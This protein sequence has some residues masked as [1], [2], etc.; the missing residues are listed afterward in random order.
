MTEETGTAVVSVADRIKAKIQ[1]VAER[2]AP[3]GGNFIKLTKAK[4]FKLPDGE[5]REGPLSVVVLD[6]ISVNSYFDRPYR[7]GEITPPACFA[8]GD[9]PKALVPHKTAPAPQAKACDGCPNNEFGSKGAGKACQN[10]RLLAV[11]APGDDPAAPI[12]LIKVSPTGLKNWDAYIQLI[13]NRFNTAEFG[14]ITEIYFD[15]TKEYQSLKFGNPVVNPFVEQD[16]TR[17]TEARE[18]LMVAPDVSSYEAPTK[19]KGRK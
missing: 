18:L 16:A 19:P 4:Q 11:K 5:E 2:T 12:Y 17:L 9:N 6:F 1:A 15:E 8:M 3:A 13:K 7:D 14:V 10:Q